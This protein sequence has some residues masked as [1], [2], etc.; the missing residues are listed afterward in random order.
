MQEESSSVREARLF[1]I[2]PIAVDDEPNIVWNGALLQNIVSRAT[3]QTPW[4][5]NL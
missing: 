5:R 4:S 2:A 1:P 3:A